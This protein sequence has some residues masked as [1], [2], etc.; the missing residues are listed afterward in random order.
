M[1]RNLLLVMEKKEPS[2]MNVTDITAETS[3]KNMG[4]QLAN[5]TSVMDTVSST[6]TSIYN[7]ISKVSDLVSDNV[8]SKKYSSNC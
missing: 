5:N 4:N 8:V 1:S 2:T 3:S 7:T 6:K